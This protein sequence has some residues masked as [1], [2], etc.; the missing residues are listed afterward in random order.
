LNQVKNIIVAEELAKIGLEDINL[1][2]IYET[3][4]KKGFRINCDFYHKDGYLITPNCEINESQIVRKI[5]D[6]FSILDGY[7]IPDVSYELRTKSNISIKVD[8]NLEQR[9]IDLLLSPNLRKLF[10]YRQLNTELTISNANKKK[11]K[12]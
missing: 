1:W 6:L 10:D 4:P 3:E 2:E 5:R 12:L 7:E 8:E 9:F 11:F